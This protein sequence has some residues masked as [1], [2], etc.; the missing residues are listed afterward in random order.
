[1]ARDIG[2]TLHEADVTSEPISLDSLVF[3]PG[4]SIGAGLRAARE[5]LGYSLN[6]IADYTKIRP[7][8]LASLEGMALD[9]LPS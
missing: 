4:V 5:H 2:G 8:Y 7:V 1:M 6:D 9:Q 3:A